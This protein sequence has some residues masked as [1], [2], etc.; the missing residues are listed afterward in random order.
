MTLLFISLQL[1]QLLFFIGYIAA[2]F[3]DIREKISE[4]EKHIIEN[5]ISQNS[6]KR[7]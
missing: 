7:K 2:E 3:L 4:T 5:I 6:K 1:F